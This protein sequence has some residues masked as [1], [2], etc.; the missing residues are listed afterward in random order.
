MNDL[1]REICGVDPE[2]K[3]AAG[4]LTGPDLPPEYCHYKDEGCECAASCLACP[5]PQCLYDEPRG[6]QRWFKN[7]RNK[8]IKKLFS[9]GRKV[10]DL[11]VMFGVSPRTIQRALNEGQKK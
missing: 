5:F 7:L 9:T 10:E 11:A 3:N 1:T 2:K 4:R 8:E 6:K